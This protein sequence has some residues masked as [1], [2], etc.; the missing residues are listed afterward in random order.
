LSSIFLVY[1]R[2]KE[3]FSHSKYRTTFDAHIYVTK[4]A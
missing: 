4:Q 3:G 1:S 2:T